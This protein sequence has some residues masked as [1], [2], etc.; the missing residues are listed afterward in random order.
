MLLGVAVVPLQRDVHDDPVTLREDLDGLR[1]QGHL[2]PVEVLHEGGD[3][4]LVVE[5]VL[6]VVPLVG[7]GDEDARG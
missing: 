4:P 5:A 1:R 3:P 7:E 2:V 6:L